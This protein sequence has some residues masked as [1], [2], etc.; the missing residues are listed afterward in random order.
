M[1]HFNEHT[2]ELSIM[3]LFQQEKYIYT[4]GEEIHK[5]AG[6]VLLRD[7]MRTYL[8]NRYREAG[9]T[10]LEIES[11]LAR[12]TANAGW[13]LYDNNAQTYRLMTEGFSLEREDAALSDL[14]IEPIDFNEEGRD[15]NLFRVVNQLEIKGTEK[16]IPDGI[17]YV[18]GC[19]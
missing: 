17:V 11:V 2:L 6:E 3:E 12:L 15:N 19:R 14:F 7:D 10:S 9:I 1:S 5:E 4:C 13:S 16:R 8:R 18:N